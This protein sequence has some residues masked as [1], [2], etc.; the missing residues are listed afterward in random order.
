MTAIKSLIVST[1]VKVA[2]PSTSNRQAL[3]SA[4][5]LIFHLGF[6]G[7]LTERPY[8]VSHK[9]LRERSSAGRH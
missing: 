1:A 7:P 2:V 6:L 4:L 5:H 8:S 9:G 3:L